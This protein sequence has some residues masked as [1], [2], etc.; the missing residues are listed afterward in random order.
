M[1]DSGRATAHS[2]PDGTASTP[3]RPLSTLF[4]EALV[5]RWRLVAVFALCQ[6]AAT[7]TALA[8]TWPGAVVGTH[9][10]GRTDFRAAA[11]ERP[12]LLVMGSEG[13]GLSDTATAACKTLV[14]IPMLGKLDSLNLAVATAL[15]LFEIQ[16]PLLQG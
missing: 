12:A 16:R 10:K 15:M 13:D 2:S 9:L 14:R 4:T 3:R 5:P 6:L 7:F 11:Y 8:A 1:T